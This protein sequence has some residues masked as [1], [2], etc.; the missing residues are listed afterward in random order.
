VNLNVGQEGRLDFVL[1]PATLRQTV[2]VE[3]GAPSVQSNSVGVNTTIGPQFVENLALNGRTFQP[4]IGLVP[5]VILTNGDGQ[6]STNGQRDNANY[7]TIDGVSANIGLTNFRSLGQTAGGSVPGFN[8]LGGTNNLVSVDAMQ[9]FTGHTS[10][11]SAEFGRTPGGQVQV[12]TRS[13]TNQFHG[14]L[15]NYF[16]NDALDAN[17]WFANLKGL[18][19]PPLRQNNFG[20]VL[21]GP[22]FKNRTFFFSSYEGLRLTSPQFSIVNVP[23]RAARVAAP[24]AI[25]QLLNAF[26]LPNGPEDPAS[27]LGQFSAAYSNPATVDAASFRLDHMVNSR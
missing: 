5:G 22:M 23:S 12:V 17:D 16:R 7:F 3:S 18:R 15:F 24:P 26:P 1:A 2:I 11:Y 19:K 6:F 21:G 13:G 8:V 4:L 27:M 14:T 9:E 10:T 20:G 25:Q